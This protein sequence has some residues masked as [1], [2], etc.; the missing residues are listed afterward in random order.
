MLAITTYVFPAIIL[1]PT[2][3]GII[4]S[5]AELP[6]GRLCFAGRSAAHVLLVRG[7]DPLHPARHLWLRGPGEPPHAPRLLV[8]R[9]DRAAKQA[10]QPRFAGARVKRVE[11]HRWRPG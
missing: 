10:Y 5:A 8:H 7:Q 4:A 1:A 3:P 11:P 9:L 6:A 2:G